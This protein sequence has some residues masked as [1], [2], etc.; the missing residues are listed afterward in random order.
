VAGVIQSIGMRI[1]YDL[2]ARTVRQIDAELATPKEGSLFSSRVHSRSIVRSKQSGR[3]QTLMRY[4][5]MLR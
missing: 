5:S 4:R 3:Y 1:N 2:I